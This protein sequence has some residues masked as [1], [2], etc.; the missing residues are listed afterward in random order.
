MPPDYRY[1]D[2][3]KEKSV[4]DGG[5][6]D[7]ELAEVDAEDYDDSE[8]ESPVEEPA[9]VKRHNVRS[10]PIVSEA[11]EIGCMALDAD[12]SSSLRLCIA[13]GCFHRWRLSLTSLVYLSITRLQLQRPLCLY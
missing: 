13:C 4:D 8:P 11:G 10:S 2:R 9:V 5:D 12:C 7:E 3:V 1:A 6:Y